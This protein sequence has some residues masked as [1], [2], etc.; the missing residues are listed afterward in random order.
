MKNL[1]VAGSSPQRSFFDADCPTECSAYDLCGGA[2]SRP[3][4]CVRDP[5][6]QYECRTCPLTC[7]LRDASEEERRQGESERFRQGLREGRRLDRLHLSQPPQ[8]SAGLPLLVPSGTLD[9]PDGP[10]LPVRWAAVTAKHLLTR[11]RQGPLDIRPHFSS[12]DRARRDLGVMPS[13]QLLAVLNAED[14]ILEGLW[15]MDHGRI[16]EVLSRCSFAAV[17]GP[18]FS[19]DPSGTSQP[20]A[21]S[22]ISLLRHHRFVEEMSTGDALVVPNLYWLGARGLSRWVSWL[23]EHESVTVVSR[24]FSRTKNDGDA[25]REQFV[26]LSSLLRRV[27]RPLHV[28]TVGVGPAKATWAVRRLADIGCTASVVTDAPA[29][30]ALAGGR[31]LD[32]PK[33]G[34]PIRVKAFDRDRRML[35][36]DNLR[37]MERHLVRALS[38]HAIY[39]LGRQDGWIGNIGK[40]A[41]RRGESPEPAPVNGA[42]VGAWTA[43]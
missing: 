22:V 3:C 8:A 24:D 13:T 25:F 17:T 16:Q 4:H 40:F 15:G 30:I 39:D 7:R 19:V 31:R 9:I 35:V 23:R 33:H 32:Y 37:A 18:T 43:R 1:P 12:K 6:H 41:Q 11:N 26:G 10:A 21:S 27:S 14:R 38:G 36:R 2:P 28:I 34:G 42:G 29:K 20:A 5:P